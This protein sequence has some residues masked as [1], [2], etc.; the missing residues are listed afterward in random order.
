MWA[1]TNS[2]VNWEKILQWVNDCYE[3]NT[4]PELYIIDDE[5]DV[6]MYLLKDISPSGN[7]DSWGDLNKEEK[8]SILSM[9]QNIEYSSEGGFLR[10]NEWFWEQIGVPHASGIF[11]STEELNY[12]RA[13]NDN[14]DE[15]ADESIYQILVSRGL[16][17]RPGFKYGAKW[18]VYDQSMKETHADWLIQPPENAPLNLE[19][20]CLSVRL[21]EGVN[22]LWTQVIKSNDDCKFIGVKRIL[23]DK[24][25]VF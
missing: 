25:L 18:R 12:L 19:S 13:L 4:F 14:R 15:I 23:P 6:T 11:F 8:T 7:L 5:F 17:I 2:P 10:S 20:L 3:A 24:K 21:A 9:I 1:R 16:L 22:K